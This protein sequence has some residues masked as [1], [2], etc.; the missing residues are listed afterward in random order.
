MGSAES[1]KGIRT[2]SVSQQ[3]ASET[4]VRGKGGKLKGG[5]L[6]QPM[7]IWTSGRPWKKK[8]F[9]TRRGILNQYKL[10]KGLTNWAQQSWVVANGN[11]YT[12]DDRNLER[13]LKRLGLPVTLANEKEIIIFAEGKGHRCAVLR[14][15]Q[16][17]EAADRKIAFNT[18]VSHLR[19]LSIM[20]SAVGREKTNDKF[21]ELEKRIDHDIAT[22]NNPRLQRLTNELSTKVLGAADL[23]REYTQS[24]MEVAEALKL[25]IA[26]AT[27][28]LRFFRWDR[29]A[30]HDAWR[31]DEKK[32]RDQAGLLVMQVSENLE[33]SPED[34]DAEVLCSICFE[35]VKVKDTTA[36]KSCGHKFCNDCWAG[37]LQSKVQS[38]KGCV[39][40]I[41][42]YHGCRAKVPSSFFNKFLP[43]DLL[44]KY[45]YFVNSDYVEGKSDIIWCP[46][47]G[48]G[49]ALKVP[50][51]GDPPDMHCVCGYSFCRHCNKEAHGPLPCGLVDTW[52]TLILD[53]DKLSEKEKKALER[54]KQL[55][56]KM[57]ADARKNEAWLMGRARPCP[58]CLRWI[59][60][61]QGCNHMTCRTNAGGCGHEFCWL[62]LGDWRGHRSCNRSNVLQKQREVLE[63]KRKEGYWNE[64]K[65]KIFDSKEEERLAVYSKQHIESMKALEHLKS[66]RATLETV[67]RESVRDFSETDKQY[68]HGAI[69]RVISCRRTLAWSYAL[70]HFIPSSTPAAEFLEVQQKSLEE[71]TESLHELVEA[72]LKI[73]DYLSEG[74]A[75]ENFKLF[76]QRTLTARLQASA[77]ERALMT[78]CYDIVDAGL[79]PTT[80]TVDVL[81]DTDPEALM[82]SNGPD[83]WVRMLLGND[84]KK[85]DEKITIL[86]EKKKIFD[87]KEDEPEL[88]S[89]GLPQLKRGKSNISPIISVGS[90]LG[91]DMKTTFDPDEKLPALTALPK[92]RR[93]ASAMWACVLCAY[94]N[95]L[96]EGVCARCG[97]KADEFTLVN[98]DTD[99]FHQ[100]IKIMSDKCVK[101]QSKEIS[102]SDFVPLTLFIS[103]SRSQNKVMVFEEIMPLLDQK[104]DKKKKYID[105]KAPPKFR[106]LGDIRHNHPGTEGSTFYPQFLYHEPITDTLW[107]L[108]QSYS[109]ITVFDMKTGKVV[110]KIGTSGRRD[111]FKKNGFK[112]LTLTS[113]YCMTSDSKFI[114]ISSSNRR[115][116]KFALRSREPLGNNML[117]DSITAM[118]MC[119]DSK[120]L[121]VTGYYKGRVFQIDKTTFRIT[122]KYKQAF[123][124]P[125]GITIDKSKNELYVCNYN[126]QNVGVLDIVKGNLVR[127]IQNLRQPSAIYKASGYLFIASRMSDV[128]VY[129]ENRTLI[130]RVGRMMG[131][132]PERP[133]NP[134]GILAMRRKISKDFHLNQTS[135]GM[136]AGRA[137][138]KKIDVSQEG[139]IIVPKKNATWQAG[140]TVS[141]WWDTGKKSKRV[142]TVSIYLLK[143]EVS[144]CVARRVPNVGVW[145][146]KV[147]DQKWL[148]KHFEVLDKERKDYGKFWFEIEYHTRDSTELEFAKELEVLR[149]S[150]TTK[151]FLRSLLKIEGFSPTY[152]QMSKRIAPI[153]IAQKK[154]HSH[155]FAEKAFAIIERLS[156]SVLKQSKPMKPSKDGKQRMV[157]VVGMTRVD[158]VLDANLHSSTG[159]PI[160]ALSSARGILMRSME[161]QFA[162]NEKN[163]NVTIELPEECRV[164]RV[165]IGTPCGV[166][167]KRAPVGDVAVFVTDRPPAPKDLAHWDD[168][169][170]VDFERYARKT[171][172]QAQ[173]VAQGV[174]LDYE[175]I[176]DYVV[177]QSGKRT[178]RSRLGIDKDKAVNS[179]KAC[180]SSYSDYSPNLLVLG[181]SKSQNWKF[182]MESTCRNVLNTF[183]VAEKQINERWCHTSVIL[184][185]EDAKSTKLAKFDANEMILYTATDT[186]I[187]SFYFTQKGLYKKLK[188][189]KSAFVAA[190]DIEFDSKFVYVASSKGVEVFSKTLRKV[191][192]LD[193]GV[194]FSGVFAANHKLFAVSPHRE[195]GLFVYSK[196]GFKLVQKITKG[197]SQPT[198]VAYLTSYQALIVLT[199]GYP[200]I[201]SE[202][203]DKLSILCSQRD[204]A[205]YNCSKIQPVDGSSVLVLKGN[206]MYQ[207]NYSPMDKKTRPLTRKEA[208]PL[209][210]NG[211][212]YITVCRIPKPKNENL[213]TVPEWEMDWNIAKLLKLGNGKGG[214]STIGGGPRFLFRYA[215]SG[216]ALFATEIP[217]RGP[218]TTEKRFSRFRDKLT[219]FRINNMNFTGLCA[220]QHYVYGVEQG[221]HGLYAISYADI[222]KTQSNQQLDLVMWG[223]RHQTQFNISYP[224][225]VDCDEKYLYVIE[226]AS[227]RLKVYKKEIPTVGN[228]PPIS[229]G[230][231]IFQSNHSNPS[232]V[233]VDKAHVYVSFQSYRCV[234]KYNKNGTMS[235]VAMCSNVNSPWGLDVAGNLLIVATYSQHALVLINK[236]TMTM[237]TTVRHGVING[238]TNV[239]GCAYDHATRTLYSANYDTSNGVATTVSGNNLIR[240]R[241]E[242]GNINART[243]ARRV[244]AICFSKGNSLSSE[245]G[246][247]PCGHDGRGLLRHIRVMQ[248]FDPVAFV[249]CRSEKTTSF[250]PP[251]MASYGKYVTFKMIRAQS[252]GIFGLSIQKELT[253]EESSNSLLK[254]DTTWIS[255]GGNMIYSFNPAKDV[256]T[257]S[258]NSGTI[259]TIRSQPVKLNASGTATIRM[260]VEKYFSGDMHLGILTRTNY[261]NAWLQNA[262]YQGAY[263]VTQSMKRWKNGDIVKF[264][265]NRNNRTIQCFNGDSKVAFQSFFSV[266]LPQDRK[267]IYAACAIRNNRNSV[268]LLDSEKKKRKPEPKENEMTALLSKAESKNDNKTFLE[269]CGLAVSYLGVS[270]GKC[271][272]VE[273]EI[274]SRVLAV[275]DS[276]EGPPAYKTIDGFEVR[277]ERKEPLPEI[278]SGKAT[279]NGSIAETA[280]ISSI[281]RKLS[282]F[283]L[284]KNLTHPVE[285]I[286]L[287]AKLFSQDRNLCYRAILA[288]GVLYSHRRN[289]KDKIEESETESEESK[290]EELVHI[291]ILRDILMLQAPKLSEGSEGNESKE[292]VASS[293]IVSALNGA[294]SAFFSLRREGKDEKKVQNENAR[295]DQKEG[296]EKK[297]LAPPVVI[298]TIFEIWSHMVF[299]SDK[300]YNHGLQWLICNVGNAPEMLHA[301]IVNQSPGPGVRYAAMR[302]IESLSNANSE[303][304]SALGHS[305]IETMLKVGEKICSDSSMT[306]A[307]FSA[308]LA[309]L[310]W[311]GNL[312]IFQ[313]ANGLVIVESIADALDK[314]IVGLLMEI[315]ELVKLHRGSEA[316]TNNVI[317][318]FY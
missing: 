271:K 301:A 262:Q 311:K 300:V 154:A 51:E 121:Y 156:S 241:D 249:R 77:A 267:H 84:E 53:H 292:T 155:F 120:H 150:D 6:S 79:L 231:I 89:I 289:L 276:Y 285:L 220:D 204:S 7:E 65:L 15:P 308:L 111:D 177:S 82:R 8:F 190:Q 88:P 93:Q 90:N 185:R 141:I 85:V 107:I 63:R 108:H 173:F 71:C 216:N 128:Q 74:A 52:G 11:V 196:P 115:I 151:D 162:T 312:E 47:A 166:Q 30:L 106:F 195:G 123:K 160:G 265:Y 233:A 176:A 277:I 252:T 135:V 137:R 35:N 67:V 236:K 244:R 148:D 113:P 17:L 283:E 192:T 56:A 314:D 23:Q 243:D 200:V 112:W 225:D 268:R 38:G 290:K 254:W 228:S 165:E 256:A 92:L 295:K 197:I 122:K 184:G 139:G 45:N 226:N 70:S 132:G 296:K 203:Y 169:K 64:V 98:I 26:E 69:R 257:K 187:S 76:Q 41:C 222:R 318:T 210:V 310:Q 5:K 303:T 309:L 199:K 31:E 42:M 219:G 33:R 180:L 145:K 293:G 214:K 40:T 59:E 275:L 248:Q 167:A 97:C 317:T 232:G 213:L 208:K 10:T 129:D 58:K 3:S 178:D 261:T 230:T 147:P 86:E 251:Y 22:L 217:L 109:H 161:A 313:K 306:A 146:W 179:I 36:I 46:A 102:P 95:D 279:Q 75:S 255:S 68:L 202:N 172:R 171:M 49:R 224:V 138:E 16:D 211:L 29:S 234:H 55:Q 87:S 294:L 272:V 104:D 259:Y 278:K 21:Q 181:L 186:S 260:K 194:H 239:I 118:G 188:E 246:P 43:K 127:W 282:H 212:S 61:N 163:A 125:W 218:K 205:L 269:G 238:L 175:S 299:K 78:A 136:G 316:K 158:E 152:T 117:P 94:L 134:L 116:Y 159:K 153:L 103:D 126:A 274:K 298:R 144:I 288:A 32:V 189:V 206:T 270:C 37:N 12:N 91:G 223:R 143:D 50:K 133:M 273:G 315:R 73:L 307:F 164:M 20:A 142:D 57:M 119:N 25:T 291:K 131:E 182:Y 124:Y 72:P 66:R 183:E 168:A 81:I 287:A 302:A 253:S 80:N 284:F 193:S 227:R 19:S 114:Y 191:T 247:P 157:E 44:E 237:I 221:Y 170:M 4:R 1:T 96:G 297:I 101:L 263:A 280:S 34:P 27:A 62:C 18:A 99:N 229:R 48:C 100:K 240:L 83:W 110:D 266:H 201:L 149:N 140:Q 174:G 130:G 250:I 28:A 209:Y 39:G 14:P 242:K 245:F 258:Q 286:D 207:Y 9:L 305:L 60:K 215:G 264:V 304:S 105:P 54:K 281:E 2:N 24:V 198:S 13:E 235:F